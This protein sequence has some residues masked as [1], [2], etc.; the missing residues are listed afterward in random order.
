MGVILPQ[1]SGIFMQK[2]HTT[3]IIIIYLQ[4][5]IVASN[6]KSCEMKCETAFN[7]RKKFGMV[8]IDHHTTVH[9]IDW[10][11]P[12]GH[13]TIVHENNCAPCRLDT[14]PVD[15]IVHQPTV[16]RVDCARVH[17]RTVSIEHDHNCAPYRLST[18]TIVHRIGWAPAQQCTTVTILLPIFPNLCWAYFVRNF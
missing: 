3:I 8:P 14:L 12:T 4:N 17:L 1:Y 6:C 2:R 9:G 13:G 5:W 10:A 7:L 16:H 11:Q 18:S 15:T